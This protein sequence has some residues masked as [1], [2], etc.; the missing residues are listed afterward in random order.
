MAN[1]QFRYDGYMR[2][3]GSL[4]VVVLFVGA[5]TKKNE[6][7]Y[8][9]DETCTTPDF[10]FCDVS[11]FASGEAGTCVAVTCT[12]QAFGE[13][14]GD[15]EVRCN[16]AGTNYNVVQCERGCDQNA[17]GCRLCDPGET[18]CTN[19]TVATCNA[20]GAVVSKDLCPLGCFEDQ[21]RCRDIAPSNDLGRFLDMV[22]NA[23]DLDL[24]A[25]ATIETMS[26]TVTTS[27][28]SMTV[29]SF[30]VSAPPNG[31][32]I[33]VIVAGMVRL[34]DV[35]VAPGGPTDGPAL[36]IIASGDI[37]VAG[38]LSLTDVDRPTAGG[39]AFSNCRGAAGSTQTSGS[40]VV[41]SGDGGGG[42]ATAGGRGGGVDF[43]QGV[44][45]GAGGGVSGTETLV[46]LRGGCA[47][48]AP[49][50]GAVQLSSRKHIEVL[51]VIDANGGL[52]QPAAASPEPGG[53]AGGG[54][55]LEAPTVTLGAQAKL[56]A[57]GGSGASCAAYPMQSQTLEPAMG[58]AASGPYCAAGGNGGAVGVDATAG[59]TA[60]YTTSTSVTY[61]QGGGGGGG[62]GRA[63]INTR[64]G[65]YT[66]ASS[67][68]EAAALTTGAL[69]TR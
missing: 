22:P 31:A 13:C 36:A 32:A 47:G 50:G 56:L 67:S 68:I 6:E 16:D 40:Q 19:G 52:I 60:S 41:S 2:W 15:L 57:N 58:G 59:G 54:I 34:G 27:A 21:P 48:S 18:A 45:G 23:P 24:S 37:T 46:P 8:C 4:L 62:L 35:A 55:L 5:C 42:H 61:F 1:P 11:G 33:R 17:D 30:L 63:R 20:S 51:G 25:G 26:G 38:R 69:Q 44:P 53:G 9:T 10:P 3:A 29:P 7:K 14:R 66:K 39:V 28:G 65:T 43:Q 12:P 64:D 49:G